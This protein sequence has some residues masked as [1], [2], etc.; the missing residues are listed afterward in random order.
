M[1]CCDAIKIIYLEYNQGLVTTTAFVF[2]LYIYLRIILQWIDALSLVHWWFFFPVIS[3]Y[4]CDMLYF[5]CTHK[6]GQNVANRLRFLLHIQYNVFPRERY[7]SGQT[8]DIYYTY[9]W[10]DIFCFIF[11]MKYFATYAV[12]TCAKSLALVIYFW[13]VYINTV[14]S[15]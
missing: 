3:L 6:F 1:I 2:H 11:F 7:S 14:L 4:Y 15:D 8:H 10:I 5:Y 12:E 9:V 13:R